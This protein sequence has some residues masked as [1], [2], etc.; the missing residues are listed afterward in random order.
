MF[1]MEKLK[2]ACYEKTLSECYGFNG[3][4]TCPLNKIC[5]AGFYLD[6]IFEP[7]LADVLEGIAYISNN[8]PGVLIC[9]K[10][11]LL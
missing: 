6:I 4:K 5:P 8:M 10:E 1:T 9:E 2:S 11:G 7:T 3:N